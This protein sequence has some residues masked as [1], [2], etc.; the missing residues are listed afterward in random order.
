MCFIAL[1]SEKEIPYKVVNDD[2]VERVSFRSRVVTG[3]AAYVIIAAS[4][5]NVDKRVCEWCQN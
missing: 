1:D 2:E 4:A 3:S 5:V